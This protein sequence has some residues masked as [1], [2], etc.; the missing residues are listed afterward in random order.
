MNNPT[1]QALEALK[2][3]IDAKHANLKKLEEQKH[4]I[5]GEISRDTASLQEDERA[6]RAMSDELT[7][8]LHSP[9]KN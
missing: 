3:S 6:L 5:E 7:K 2:K 9:K 4:H 8:A 1:Q